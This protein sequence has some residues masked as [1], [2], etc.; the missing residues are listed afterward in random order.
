MA[1]LRRRLERAGASLA[2][3]SFG[4]LPGFGSGDHA[5]AL[6]VFFASADAI[7][8]GLPATRPAVMP[9]GAFVAFCRRLPGLARPQG[10]AEAKAFIETHF[11]PWRVVVAQRSGFLTGYFEPEIA[12][13]LVETPGFRAPVLPRPS[14]LATFRPGE[15][16]AGLDPALAAARKWPDGSLTP[17]PAR[18]EI[19]ALIAPNDPRAL[20]WLADWAESFLVQVQGSARV[21]LPDG[22]LLRLA[23]DGRNGR[24]Y[25]SIGRILIETGKI[26]EAEMSLSRLKAWLRAAGLEP[27]QAGRLLLQRNESFVFFKIDPALDPKD[28]P[29]GAAGVSLTPLRS[30]AVDRGIWF[31]GLPFWIDARLTWQGVSATPF[32]RLMV[33]QDTGSAILGPARAD[34]FFGWGDEAGALAGGIRHPAEF[35]VLLP[36]DGE[37]GG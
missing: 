15:T 36:R 22:K 27:A 26:P 6:E 35:A 14:D 1:E 25:T 9:D 12:A 4:D 31:Y 29:V 23:Y 37:F 5:A 3:A 10:Q 2:P 20:V 24:P 7:A 30:I 18:G 19:E 21:R 8:D 11:S 16:P 17:Y 33:A 34:L 32:Q 28:G 13:S